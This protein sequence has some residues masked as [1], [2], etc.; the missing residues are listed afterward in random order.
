MSFPVEGRTWEAGQFGTHNVPLFYHD[1]RYRAYDVPNFYVDDYIIRNEEDVKETSNVSE[2][3]IS[4]IEITADPAEM[5]WGQS[6]W[7]I[8][9][10]PSSGT[11]NFYPDPVGSDFWDGPPALFYNR[12]AYTL[13]PT[14][15]ED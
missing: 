12:A 5:Q 2:L 7:Q 15:F 4:P 8:T 11:S 1:V 10:V 6:K 14:V 9:A 3:I 13:Y